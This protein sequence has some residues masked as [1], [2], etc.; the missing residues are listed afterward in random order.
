LGALRGARTQQKT[1]KISPEMSPESTE[2]TVSPSRSNMM[3]S[4]AAASRAVSPAFRSKLGSIIVWS[5]S[6]LPSSMVAA[7]TDCVPDVWL[8]ELPP[9]I[10]LV[11]FT[12]PLPHLALRP[13]SN[14]PDCDSATSLHAGDASG[15]PCELTDAV[16]V[17]APRA[18]HLPGEAVVKLA[19]L[20]C[21][22]AG[23]T[24]AERSTTPAARASDIPMLQRRSICA[25][26]DRL[27]ACHRW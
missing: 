16:R 11:R 18:L 1:K 4:I 27:R 2:E 3:L 13:P 24:G 12:R 26:I 20:C 22:A 15:P 8:A 23:V 10:E 17:A 19:P 21:P 9:S 5:A 25:R 6:S 7:F 14:S